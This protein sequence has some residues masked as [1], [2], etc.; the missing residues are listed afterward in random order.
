MDRSDA[1][2][3]EVDVSSDALRILVGRHAEFIRFLSPRVGSD[4][5]AEDILQQ[6]LVR[7]VEHAEDLESHENVVAWFYTVLR[8]L[9]VDLHRN[10]ASTDRKHDAFF[11][12]LE[13]MG[14]S[15]AY[16][17]TELGRVLC[18]CVKDLFDTLPDHYADVLRKVDLEGRSL[19]EEAARLETSKGALTVKLHR[20]RQALKKRLEQMCGT[21][22][23]HGCLD[24]SCK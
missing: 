22:T 14:S 18:A 9:L 4:A 10:R 3:P 13:S 19:G 5:A 21:C 23:Q 11:A 16:Q 2:R 6:G 7:A 8:N 24:C 17:E 1:V 15:H 20:A 12:E